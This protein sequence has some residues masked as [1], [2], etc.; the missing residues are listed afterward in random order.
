MEKLRN[1]EI[2]TLY[3]APNIVRNIKS[4]GWEGHVARISRMTK[5]IHV[6]GEP[7]RRDHVKGVGVDERMILKWVVDRV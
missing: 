5:N 2:H 7:E 6:I 3:S 4:F 1:D